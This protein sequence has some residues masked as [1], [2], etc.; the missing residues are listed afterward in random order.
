[1]KGIYKIQSPSGNFYIGSSTNVNKRLAAHKRQLKN[2]THIN[3]ALRNA[4]EK[5][6][7]DNISFQE[8]FCVF[9]DAQL[10]TVEQELIDTLMPAYNI[11]KLADCALFDE[12]VCKKRIKA[13]SKQVIR[14]RDGKVF[15]SGYEAAR[16]YNSKSPDN[17]STAIKNGWK[18]EGEFW[19]YA[20]SPI[21]Y[22][23]AVAR[24]NHLEAVRKINASSAAS[25][26]RSKMVRRIIDGAI[27]P[28]AVFA[29]RASGGHD[30][31][32]SE[33]ISLGVSRGG[34]FWEYV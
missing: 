8:Y 22:E 1:M 16:C 28:S 14:L 3:S 5:Y 24:W 32:V 29:S 2:G 9:D 25:S 7:V 34:S 23:Q 10:R 18:F 6:G 13:L 11:S 30:K 17:L 26:A 4:V 19:C 15:A 27:F 33:A 31:M 12:V 21:N 20:Q